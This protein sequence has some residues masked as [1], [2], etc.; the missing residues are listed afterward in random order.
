MVRV[1]LVMF[2]ADKDRRVIVLV[3][4]LLNLLSPLRSPGLES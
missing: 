4:G 3:G 2:P 1:L